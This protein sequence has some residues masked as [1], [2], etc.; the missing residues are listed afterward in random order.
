[1]DAEDNNGR[2][3]Y[4]LYRWSFEDP[5][6]KVFRDIAKRLKKVTETDLNQELLKLWSG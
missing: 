6:E 5:S 1:M 3:D 4:G 2:I